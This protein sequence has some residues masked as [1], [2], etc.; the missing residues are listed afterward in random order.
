MKVGVT[1]GDGFIG[2]YVMS[3]LRSRGH[4]ALSF[5]RSNGSNHDIRNKHALM[6]FLDG[7][8]AV[9]HLAGILGTNELFKDPQS[10]VDIN[11][12]GTINVMKVCRNHQLRYVAIT[13]P[14]VWKNLYQA[15]KRAAKEM[16]EIWHDT[17]D[18]PISFVRAYNVFGPGQKVHGVKKIIPTF[19]SQAWQNKPIPIWGDGSQ[20]V[21]LV[22]VEDVAKLLVDALRFGNGEVLEAG[23][24]SPMPVGEVAQIVL[25]H[26]HSSAGVQYLP[27]RKGEQLTPGWE[28]CADI[29]TTENLVG[30]HPVYQ[31]AALADTI[32]W[33][34]YAPS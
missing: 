15:T 19:A 11:I 10:A 7:A 20:F 21:D 4:T 25:S 22:Y 3:E 34:K 28:M 9:I 23:T 18:V 6:G 17:Y 29:T 14:S 8:D 33:Y 24:G 31:A 32:D 30:W 27:M 12:G 16:A 2:K 1:G 13:M 26:T 5:D